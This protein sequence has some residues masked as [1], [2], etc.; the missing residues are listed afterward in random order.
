M[1]GKIMRIK[2][3]HLMM[4][5]VGL[6]IGNTIG[7]ASGMSVSTPWWVITLACIIA[8]LFYIFL[9]VLVEAIDM[10]NYTGIE[11]VNRQIKKLD[12]RIL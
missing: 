1:K 6:I 8:S 5:I 9:V 2:K 12:K 3:G 4:W 11:N 7:I 10:E